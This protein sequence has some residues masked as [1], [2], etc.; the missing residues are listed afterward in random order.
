MSKKR[1]KKQRILDEIIDLEN[2]IKMAMS[3]RNF[4]NKEDIDRNIEKWNN[5][6]IKL[7]REYGKC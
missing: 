7:K 6:I 1:N 2:S 4:S 3:L 5:K